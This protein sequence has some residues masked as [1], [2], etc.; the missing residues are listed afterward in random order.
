ME[1]TWIVGIDCATKESKVGLS[2]GCS[3]VDGCEIMSPVV[4][5]RGMLIAERVASWI[6]GKSRTLIALDSPL[7]WPQAMGTALADHRAG[8][9]LPVRS[10][11]LF[12][13][14]TDRFVRKQIDKQ[15]LDVGAD[16]IARTAH[17]SLDLVEH[18]RDLTGLPIPLAWTPMYSET[19]AAI[20]V[21]P[22]ATLLTHGIPCGNYKKKADV[23]VRSVMLDHLAKRV[24]LPQDRSLPLANADALDAMVC[25]LAGYDF[26]S[27]QADAPADSELASQEGW[28]WFKR[29]S[30]RPRLNR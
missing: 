20:E 29:K 28:I 13:R 19:V 16:R 7:G 30:P 5:P 18:L 15:S 21:Y 1:T 12:R 22:A 10:N 2:L 6:D 17:W 23:A 4:L 27:G 24:R 26:L 9:R 25:V 8:S 3:T 11:D 14:D